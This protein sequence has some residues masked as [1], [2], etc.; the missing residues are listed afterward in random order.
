MVPENY[1]LYWIGRRL[2]ARL[3]SAWIDG[4]RFGLMIKL[5][6][7]FGVCIPIMR[8]SQTVAPA[9]FDWME[10]ALLAPFDPRRGM[11][12]VGAR[13]WAEVE[14]DHRHIVVESHG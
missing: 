4:K 12:D 6:L 7:V 1:V 9:L 13:T 14:K 2:M 8:I 5:A 11:K 3:Q 10:H